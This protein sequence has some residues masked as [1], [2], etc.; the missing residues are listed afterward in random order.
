MIGRLRFLAM[1]LVLIATGCTSSWRP[2]PLV[3]NFGLG[4]LVH[5]VEIPETLPVP[6]C[7]NGPPDPSAKE[8]VYIFGINGLNPMCLGNFNGLL[9]YFREQGFT[10][11][12]FG[13]PYT[14]FW[15]PSEIREIRRQDPQ[16]KIVLIGFSSG[17]NSVRAMANG[18]NN[19]GTPID[20]LVYLVG[21]TIWDTPYSK[22]GNVRRIV[23]IRAQ[24][25]LLL[26]GDLLFN[27]ADL[28][29]ARNYDLR[30]RHILAPSRPET[31]TLMMEEL[32]ALTCRPNR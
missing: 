32:L 14:S 28:E 17:A 15:F 27:G 11:T 8:H 9:C 3:T 23:N 22:P 4:H 16:A 13:Q 2:E 21:D 18:L 30:C 10:H 26:G 25:L 5:P 7:C 19:D 20:L 31:V 6:I 24:G 12:Y 1:G 29:G